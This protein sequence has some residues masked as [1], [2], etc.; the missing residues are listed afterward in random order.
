MTSDINTLIR[1]LDR[2]SRAG[3][4]PRVARA[5][6]RIAVLDLAATT[7]AQ[8]DAMARIRTRLLDAQDAGLRLT[9]TVH[10]RSVDVD[11]L[12]FRVCVR[13]KEHGAL[14]VSRIQAARMMR[15]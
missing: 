2:A 12:L 8:R 14:F 11:A 6:R 15:C 9:T 5:L 13:M 3:S 10:R 7:P 4:V 1:V